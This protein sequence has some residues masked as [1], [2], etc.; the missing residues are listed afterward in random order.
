MKKHHFILSAIIIN[1]LVFGTIYVV[2]QQSLRLGANSPQQQLAEDTAAQLNQGVAP[3]SLVQGKVDLK[4][5]LAPFVII[6][7][8]E[9]KALAGSGYLDSKIPQVPV[10][11]LRHAS[12]NR[13]NAVTWEPEDGVRLA[14]VS[15]VANK[16]YVLSGRSL[17]QVDKTTETALQLTAVGWLASTA[18]LTYLEVQFPRA[19]RGKKTKR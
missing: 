19:A 4:T 3:E 14:T 6:Y 11:V 15:A 10:G 2:A 12:S 9:G 5:S 18:I 1:T 13:T 17:R 16:Y 8:Q 7:D